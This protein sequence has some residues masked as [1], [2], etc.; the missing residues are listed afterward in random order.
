[1]AGLPLVDGK[2]ISADGK[3]N[4]TT[5]AHDRAP[6]FGTFLETIEPVA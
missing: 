2:A 4:G 5:G 6:D 1:M 3:R